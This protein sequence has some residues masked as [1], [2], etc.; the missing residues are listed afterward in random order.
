[1]FSA[2][3]IVLYCGFSNFASSLFLFFFFSPV[4]LFIIINLNAFDV[5]LFFVLFFILFLII[6]F[7]INKP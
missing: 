1:M 5:A 7:F 6:I 4:C 3:V 2:V